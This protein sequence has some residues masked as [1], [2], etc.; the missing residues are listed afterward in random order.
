V[1]VAVAAVVVAVVEAVAA[2]ASAVFASGLID[3][4]EARDQIVFCFL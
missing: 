1:L 3:S 4:S 2:A